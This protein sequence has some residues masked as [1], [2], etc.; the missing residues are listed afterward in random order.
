MKKLLLGSVALL[1]AAGVAMLSLG[2][3]PAYLI[4]GP[5]VAAGIGAKLLCSA[6]HVI[7]NDRQSAF[8]DVAQYSPILEQIEVHYDDDAKTVT[9]SFMGISSKTAS[10]LPGLG[11]AIDFEGITERNTVTT[12]AAVANDAPWPMGDGIETLDKR[13]QTA[14]DAMVKQ[15]NDQGFNTRALL[16]VHN[17][18]IVAESY[19]QGA[20]PN[21]PLLGWSMA[22]SMT[23]IALGN[24]EMRGLLDLSARPAFTGWDNDDRRDIRITDLLTMTDGLRF[25]EEYNP[26]DDSTSMLFTVASASDYAMQVDA[27][28]PPGSFFNYSSGTANLLARLQRDTAG[29][30]QSAYDDLMAAVFTPM[31]M[32]NAIFEMD[33][34]G[35]FVGSSYLYASAR[36]WARMG[37]LMLDGGVINGQRIVTTDWVARAT[38]PN[39]SSNEKAY[40]YQWW[41]NDGDAQL[42]YPNLPSEAYFANGNRQQ[43]V[44]VVPSANAVIVRLGWTDGQYPVDER[45]AALLNAL[46][47]Q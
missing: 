22:K 21:T 25:S 20:T 16:V 6:E 36:D 23:A 28:H 11:C 32:Q 9:A 38:T 12:G 13:M 41:L 29:S 39:P 8:A 47:E 10:F 14:V 1:V 17:G 42:R 15:D 35:S 27:A 7:G 3:T 46:T 43:V 33:A 31:G 2:L 5:G 24:L 4:H 19:A 45:F 37:Q 18:Q 40:G 30:A 34:A 44:M 26:G